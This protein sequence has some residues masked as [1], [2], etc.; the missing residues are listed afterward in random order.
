M[1]LDKFLK[2]TRLIKRRTIAKEVIE[3]DVAY[4]NG[5]LAKPSKEV[6]VGDE[7]RLILG[8][9]ELTIRV[10]SLPAT[11]LKKDTKEMYEVLSLKVLNP[12]QPS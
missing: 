5:R 1:R 11:S 8:K 4:V 12:S 3:Q 10:M 7:I 6:Q 2:I 9:K